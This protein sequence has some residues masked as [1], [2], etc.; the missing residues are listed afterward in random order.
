MTDQDA[1]KLRFPNELRASDAL[2]DCMN[3]MVTEN[4]G[5]IKTRDEVKENDLD[6]LVA[7][8]YGK[9]SKTFIATLELSFLG[10][11]DDALILLRSNINL[12]INLAFILRKEPV[13][14][15]GDFIAYSYL[16]QKKYLELRVFPA[17]LN[18]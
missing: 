3:R 1:R 4:E 13:Q 8:M 12:L 16:E 14:R 5:K 10:Y 11:G 15:A 7:A 17:S 2:I 6:Q 9:A 18:D